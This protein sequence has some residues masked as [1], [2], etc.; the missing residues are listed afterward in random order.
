MDKLDYMDIENL[1]RRFL[2][3][4]GVCTDS[5]ELEPGTIFFALRGENFD[6]NSFVLTA[7]ENGAQF[8]VADDPSLPDNDKIIKCRD[9]LKTL[10]E[11]ARFHRR[12]LGIPLL[13]LTGTNGKT[14]TKELISAVLSARYNV[15]YTK[16]NLNNHIGVPLTLLSMSSSTQIGVVEMGAS[17]PGEIAALVSVTEPDC[18]LITNI[19]K[20][21]LQGFGTLDGVRKSKGELYDYLKKSGGTILYNADNPILSEMI[22]EREPV[23]SIPYGILCSGMTIVEPSGNTPF[24]TIRYNDLYSVSTHLI[25]EYNADNVAAAL[26]AGEFFN[27]DREAAVKAIGNY[28]PS[29]NRSMLVRGNRNLL[30]VDA[31]NANPVSMMAALS[32]FRKICRNS[33]ALILGDM[34]ELG[35]ES[36]NEHRAVLKYISGMKSDIMLFV[37]SQFR[38]AAAGNPAFSSAKFFTDSLELKEYIAKNPVSGKTILIKGSRGTRLE[39]VIDLLR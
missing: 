14:T 11:L 13:A 28:I 20:A 35:E 39:R 18:G 22:R 5:R 4:K 27:V 38:A 3:S 29:N 2:L 34:L 9:S 37:G 15:T 17:A 19:G 33:C 10:Q 8:A 31:Y 26:C 30:I 6:G 25:G 21:H 36:V 1:Y 24:L 16:G 12:Q 7:L 23:K 32:N